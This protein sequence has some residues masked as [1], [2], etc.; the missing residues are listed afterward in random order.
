M[1][2]SSANAGSTKAYG[3]NPWESLGG[4]PSTIMLRK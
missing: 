4:S 2:D 1:I 3:I